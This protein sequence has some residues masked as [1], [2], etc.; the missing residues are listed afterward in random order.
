[1]STTELRAYLARLISHDRAFDRAFDRDLVEPSG[2]TYDGFRDAVDAVLAVRPRP[3]LIQGPTITIGEEKAFTAGQ[4]DII[5]R[6]TAVVARNIT[7]AEAIKIATRPLSV[8]LVPKADHFLVADADGFVV[9]TFHRSHWVKAADWAY[10]RAMEPLTPRPVTI[11]DLAVGRSW[12][13]TGTECL[14][15]SWR[16]AGSHSLGSSPA[17]YSHL[18][19]T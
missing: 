15:M 11:L 7:D 18:S 12:A 6:V 5:E 9:A 1:M 2:M 14:S 10:S 16:R 8:G 17:V 19:I 4:E 13:F 3:L